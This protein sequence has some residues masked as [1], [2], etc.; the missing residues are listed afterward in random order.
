VRLNGRGVGRAFGSKSSV[1]VHLNAQVYNLN[2]PLERNEQFE[3]SICPIKHTLEGRFDQNPS[4]QTVRLNALCCIIEFQQ[5]R[6]ENFVAKSP[7]ILNL[8]KNQC[9]HIFSF[10][11][12]RYNIWS[13]VKWAHVFLFFV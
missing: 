4:D 7:V 12:Y 13:T 3:S 6:C 2:N 5:K 8:L 11:Y 10:A 1:S 9:Q